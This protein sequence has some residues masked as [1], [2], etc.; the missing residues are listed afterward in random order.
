M[1]FE[2]YMTLVF[3]SKSANEGFARSAI[4]CFAVYIIALIIAWL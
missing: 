4:A 3:P 1:K 2:N